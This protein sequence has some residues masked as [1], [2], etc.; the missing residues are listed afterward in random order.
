MIVQTLRFNVVDRWREYLELTKPKV[1]S[2]ITFTAM[3]GKDLVEMANDE[4]EKQEFI[5]SREAL[6][7]GV[8][9]TLKYRQRRQEVLTLEEKIEVNRKSTP[10]MESVQVMIDLSFILSSCR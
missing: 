10:A 6:R 9:D 7:R 2:L 3:V 8:Q 4:T 1:V 5:N